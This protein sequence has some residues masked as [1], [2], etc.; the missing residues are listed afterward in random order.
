LIDP[1]G[2]LDL[3]EPVAGLRVF[4]DGLR[5][6]EIQVARGLE[7]IAGERLRGQSNGFVPRGS[8]VKLLPC[9]WI[10]RCHAGRG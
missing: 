8:H 10:D 2:N 4:R 5:C 3:S 9:G 6:E 7:L 1:E